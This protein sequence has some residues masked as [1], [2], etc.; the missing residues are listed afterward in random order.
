MKRLPLPK[1]EN[2]SVT[3]STHQLSQ[4]K[5]NL[6]RNNL[7]ILYIFNVFPMMQ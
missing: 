3:A 5:H 7:L 2:E 4:I 6:T 1:L